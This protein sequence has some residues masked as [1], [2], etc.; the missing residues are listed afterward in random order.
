MGQ[1]GLRTHAVGI[2]A[3]P[4][5]A[6]QVREG[7]AVNDGDVIALYAILWLLDQHPEIRHLPDGTYALVYDATIFCDRPSYSAW[8]TLDTTTPHGSGEP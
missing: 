8:V 4:G 5:G 1:G 7:A 2:L 3:A 6:G